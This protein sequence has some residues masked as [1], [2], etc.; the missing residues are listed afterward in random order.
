MMLVLGPRCWLELNIK[1]SDTIVNI[2]LYCWRKFWKSF[3]KS[4]I[5]SFQQKL[6]FLGFIWF[7]S[8]IW[9]EE[10]TGRCWAVPNSVQVWITCIKWI[11]QVSRF[12]LLRVLGHN[13]KV[14]N[15]EE[16]NLEG[17]NIERT[18]PRSDLTYTGTQPRR[19]Q[20][21]WEHKLV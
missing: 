15:L 18:Q 16:F 6:Y 4:V 10:E 19:L 9:K 7:R 8:Y 12:P 20:P 5:K 13:L 2:N 21:I 3:P 17:H 1:F 14:H 11:K